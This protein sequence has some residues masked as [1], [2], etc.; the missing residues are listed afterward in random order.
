MKNAQKKK[1]S[2]RMRKKLRALLAVSCGLFFLLVCFSGWKIYS[3]LHGYK[4]AERRYDDLAGAVVAAPSVPAA[5]AAETQQSAAQDAAPESPPPEET[6]RE[7]SPVDVDFAALREI[8]GDVI[9]WLCLPHTAINY[10]VAQGWDNVFYLDRFIDGSPAAGGTLFADYQCPSDF[11]G[12][13]TIIYGHN[14][15]D[16][17]MFA[18]ID[19]YADQSFYEQHPVM[20][21]NTPS[22]NYRIDLFSGFTAE[23]RSFV[24]TSAFSSDEDYAAFLRRLLAASEI[25]C[26]LEPGVGDRIVTLSTC[27]YSGEDVRFVLCGTLTE[28]D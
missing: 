13:N 1:N 2:R 17:S 19:D 4:D 7:R 27:T 28:I 6:P 9:G 21:L 11:S 18:L 23:P 26:G 24:Y 10:P 5:P 16:G 14:M 3:I 22:Q 8:S 25:D 15:R 12:R 20:Y